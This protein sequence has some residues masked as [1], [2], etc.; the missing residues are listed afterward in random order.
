MKKLKKINEY[1]ELPT[2]WFKKMTLA[3]L[4]SIK[5]IGN[6]S[7]NAYYNGELFLKT[8]DVNWEAKKDPEDVAATLEEMIKWA[9]K[10]LNSEF[11][12]DITAFLQYCL[13]ANNLKLRARDL[14]LFKLYLKRPIRCPS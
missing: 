12:A 10:N 11:S 2:G 6:T 4:V 7:N 8:F 1:T 13:L 5:S 3:Q 14:A 9:D